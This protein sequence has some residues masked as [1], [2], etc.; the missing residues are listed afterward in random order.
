MGRPTYFKLGT[1]ME[2]DDLITNVRSDLKGQ[3]SR[4]PSRL[5]P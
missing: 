4:S 5:M 2:Y 3:K 1:D